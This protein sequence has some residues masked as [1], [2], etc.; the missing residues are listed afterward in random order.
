[1][2]VYTG[3]EPGN[4]ELFKDSVT[5]VWTAALALH[6]SS[7]ASYDHSNTKGL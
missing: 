2:H 4:S 6:N 7:L 1:M 3:I 5:V